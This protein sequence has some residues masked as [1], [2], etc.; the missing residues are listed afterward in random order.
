VAAG[1]VGVAV[2]GHA[3]ASVIRRVSGRDEAQAKA[4]A[5]EEAAER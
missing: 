5:A 2:A 4:A 3:A 1:V